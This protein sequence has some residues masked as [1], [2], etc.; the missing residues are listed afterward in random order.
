[1]TLL[2]ATFLQ[3][4]PYLRQTRMLRTLTARRG[5]RRVVLGKGRETCLKIN[6]KRRRK[7]QKTAG[8]E[9]PPLGARGATSHH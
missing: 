3:H 7:G 6:G 8:A 1:M 5:N 4:V 9:P 2:S